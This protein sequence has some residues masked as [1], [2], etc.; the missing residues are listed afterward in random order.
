MRSTHPSYP[1]ERQILAEYDQEG[2]YV[3]QA[4][5]P[6]ITKAALANGTFADGFN[7]DRMTWIKPSFGWMLYRSSYGTAHRQESILK[8]KISHEGFLTILQD[9]V[10]TSY[11]RNLHDTETQWRDALK[12]SKVRYQWDPDRDLTLKRLERR[13]IQLGIRGSI[14]YQYVNEWILSLEEVTPLAH[15][16]RDAKE[17]K[18]TL[19]DAPELSVYDISPALAHI[20]DLD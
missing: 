3:Y 4:F 17:A 14:V 16:I 19:P 13:A 8:I 12:H 5:K 7:M 9:A 1:P 15:A 10:A 20:L 18:R 2:V 6:S 11:N